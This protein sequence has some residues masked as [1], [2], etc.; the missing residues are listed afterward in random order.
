MCLSLP[1]ALGCHGRGA[2]HL[3]FWSSVFTGF[4]LKWSS[5]ISG[6][7]DSEPKLSMCLLQELGAGPGATVGAVEALNSLR[8]VILYS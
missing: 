4:F 1:K 8:L 7:N 6:L 3:S 2:G 5:R